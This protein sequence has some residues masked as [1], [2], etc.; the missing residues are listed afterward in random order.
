MEAELLN[1]ARDLSLSVVKEWLQDLAAHPSLSTAPAVRWKE[2]LVAHFL[3]CDLNTAGAGCLPADIKVLL[4][5]SGPFR[6]FPLVR[7][8]ALLTAD[9]CSCGIIESSAGRVYYKL[10]SLQTWRSVRNNGM[11]PINLCHHK[12]SSQARDETGCF[13][14]QV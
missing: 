13:W 12:L 4:L 7:A 10:M 6:F 3:R 8:C 9:G 11:R 14:N 5:T 1:L 2:L